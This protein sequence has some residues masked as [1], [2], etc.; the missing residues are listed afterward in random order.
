MS[1]YSHKHKI[2]TDSRSNGNGAG[3]KANCHKDNRAQAVLLKKHIGAP[4][5]GN[6]ELPVQKKANTTGLPDN[7]KSGIENLSGHSLDD[8]KVHYNSAQPAQL[9]AHAYAQG[10]NIHI[11]PGQEKHLPH[12]A[13]HVVQQKQGR[14]RP[15][16]QMKGKV[17][18]NDDRGLE[19]EADVMGAKA[20]VHDTVSAS[21][22]LTVS[23]PV[24]RAVVQRWLDTKLLAGRSQDKRI[25]SLAQE[26]NAYNANRKGK[27]RTTRINELHALL[28]NS[29]KWLDARES[30]DLGRDDAGVWVKELMN[31]VQTEHQG[32]VRESVEK[33]D[34]DPP[35]ANFHALPPS[36]Q[37]RVRKIWNQLVGGTGNIRITETEDYTDDTTKQPATRAHAG[38]RYETLAQFAR[39]LETETGRDIVGQVNKDTGGNK[40]VTIRPGFSAPSQGAPE[41]EFAAG[42][43]QMDGQDKMTEVHPDQMFK[44]ERDAKRKREAYRR[45]FVEVSLGGKGDPKQKAAAIYQARRNHPKAIGVKMI[46]K[47]YKF[48][49]GTGVNVTITRDIRDGEDHHTARFVDENRKEIPSP[50]FI[51]L[52]HE[53]G[54]GI[55]ILSGVALG[56]QGVSDQ[57]MQHLGVTGK[58]KSNWS[59]M[60]EYANINSVENALRKEYGLKSRY[61]HI[62][63]P[64]VQKEHLLQIINA[65]YGLSDMQP[66]P[67]RAAVEA[68]LILA[69]TAATGLNIPEARNKIK[70]TVGVFSGQLNTAFPLFTAP[71]R[72][73]IRTKVNGIKT[74]VNSSE[75]TELAKA[76]TA[77]T[78][79]RAL[80]TQANQRVLHAQQ[81]QQAQPQPQPQQRG[82]FRRLWPF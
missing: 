81:H 7:L 44:G 26:A 46:D 67:L 35:V 24:Q 1:G 78:E 54:H 76:D 80:I 8:V 71:E 64:S 17:N 3:S 58:E 39:L 77:I 72:T 23:T 43:V 31:A 12:E 11:A 59:N 32:L 36:T 20:L 2:S 40:L 30:S 65:F 42:P 53:L 57:L 60:E 66:Q 28:V 49:A 47:Y 19:K 38:F 5:P 48:G 55:H 18:V 45:K 63:Q 52:G 70:Q 33:N 10:S 15:T 75:I 37:K 4:E 27:T 9:N 68:P 82:F 14:V 69:G 25:K 74:K 21:G 6:A 61:G 50:N 62:N 73:A 29:M 13:W 22:T 51:T 34:T 56:D 16:M 79:A 41:S